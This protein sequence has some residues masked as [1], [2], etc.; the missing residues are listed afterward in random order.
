MT[1]KGKTFNKKCGKVAIF[2]LRLNIVKFGFRS[3]SGT[4][5]LT[6]MCYMIQETIIPYWSLDSVYNYLASV[7]SFPNYC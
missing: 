5:K 4:F 6:M 1:R 3:T 7:R 2:K